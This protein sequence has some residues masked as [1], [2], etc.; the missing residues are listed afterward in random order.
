M[1]RRIP[2]GKCPSCNHPIIYSSEPKS[3]WGLVLK[4]AD[5]DFHGR[6]VICAK[7]KKMIA[8]IDVPVVV[9]EPIMAPA[10]KST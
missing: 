5:D 4:I 6:T 8:I 7:C 3:K 9:R 10:L 1:T 2:I